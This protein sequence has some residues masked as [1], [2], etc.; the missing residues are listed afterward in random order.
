MMMNQK[1][2]QP[3]QKMVPMHSMDKSKGMPMAPKTSGAMKRKA[4]AK[5]L[6]K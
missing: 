2:G 6:R 1:M 3:N 4:L 5:A